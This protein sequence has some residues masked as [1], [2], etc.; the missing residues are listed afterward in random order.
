MPERLRWF[1][2]NFALWSPT[3]AILDPF[4]FT[5]GLAENAAENGVHFFCGREVTAISLEEDGIYTI[6]AGSGRFRSRW[7]INCAGLGADKISAMLGMEDYTIYPCRGEYYVLDKR[8][9][10]TLPLPVYPVPNYKTGGLGIHLTPTL[11]GNILVGPSTEYIRS[12]GDYSS[13]REIMD[14]L[15][16]DRQPHLS[17]SE[18][19]IFY[20]EFCR[21]PSQAFAQRSGRLS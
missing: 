10:E 13:T 11:E 21:D 20:P 5:F 14:L 12:R 6:A 18:A 16:R 19:G 9:K 4:Q 1:R 8:L 3:T 17:V 2:E 15:I 7:I